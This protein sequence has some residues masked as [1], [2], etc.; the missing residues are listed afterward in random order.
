MTCVHCGS[1]PVEVGM[2]LTDGHQLTLRSCCKP[3]WYCDGQPVAL[4][5][6]LNLIPRRQRRRLAQVSA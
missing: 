6:V 5:T 1:R 2:K 3:N 4:A